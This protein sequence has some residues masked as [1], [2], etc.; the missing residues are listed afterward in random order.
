MKIIDS[1]RYY[2][3]NTHKEYIHLATIQHQLREYICFAHVSTQ[4][5]YIEEITG[6][7]LEWIADDGLAQALHDFL[8]DRAVLDMKRPLVPDKEWYTLGKR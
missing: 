2:L 6:G 7:S 3:P 4:K 5:V 1:N 8:Q